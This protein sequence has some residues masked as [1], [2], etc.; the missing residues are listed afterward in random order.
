MK[1]KIIEL[2]EKM[3]SM[4]AE[5]EALKKQE[6][7]AA[8]VSAGIHDKYADR[9]QQIQKD[10]LDLLNEILD[11]GVGAACV[12]ITAT[13]FSPNDTNTNAGLIT[14]DTLDDISEDKISAGLEV[15]TNPKRIVLLKCLSRVSLTASEI[16]KHIGLVGGQLYHHLSSLENAGLIVREG[17]R[18][19]ATSEAKILMVGL[20]GNWTQSRT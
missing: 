16:T 9:W 1:S 7:G 15:F 6:A 11:E 8:S 4:Q 3:N 17:D 2:E 19:S 5:L 10:V 18:Y 14:V 12:R 20:T 13:R